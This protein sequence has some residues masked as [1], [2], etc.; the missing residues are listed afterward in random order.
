MSERSVIDRLQETEIE[1]EVNVSDQVELLSEMGR[2]TE[3]E[4]EYVV[5]AYG[6]RQS[7]EEIAEALGESGVSTSRV[8]NLRAQTAEKT[9]AMEATLDQLEGIMALIQKQH[10]EEPPGD[11]EHWVIGESDG[12]LHIPN[13]DYVAWCGA[14]STSVHHHTD[15]RADENNSICDDCS[16][17][18]QRCPVDPELVHYHAKTNSLDAYTLLQFVNR[19]DYNNDLSRFDDGEIEIVYEADEAGPHSRSFVAFLDNSESMWDEKVEALGSYR[20]DADDELLADVLREIH[21]D[22]MLEYASQ[23]NVDQHDL[24]DALER[25]DAHFQ[26]Q[27]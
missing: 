3:K 13:G 6:T 14:Q 4:A 20:L 15:I 5:R 7:R 22:T 21:E 11:G 10:V 9:S 2:F 24:A 1:N 25:A 18:I 27:E 19:V 8:D 17:E 16:D 26:T 12:H 23:Y